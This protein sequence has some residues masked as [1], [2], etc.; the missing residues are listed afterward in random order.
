M[1][2]TQPRTIICRY[3]AEP[4]QE[5]RRLEPLRPQGAPLVDPE[6]FG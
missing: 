2:E 5:G 3:R 1:A 4:G 6:A